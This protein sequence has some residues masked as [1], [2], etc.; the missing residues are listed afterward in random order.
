MGEFF[1][2][3]EKQQILKGL[4]TLVQIAVAQNSKFKSIGFYI[5]TNILFSKKNTFPWANFFGGGEKKQQIL[6]GLFT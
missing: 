1:L 5:H 3:G 2:G 6:K 4:L